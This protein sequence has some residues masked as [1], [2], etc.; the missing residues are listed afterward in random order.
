MRK[1]SMESD[2]KYIYN[3]LAAMYMQFQTTHNM[4]NYNNQ[5]T[6]LRKKYHKKPILDNF[7]TNLIISWA[8]V[9]NQLAEDYRNGES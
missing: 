6:E 8:P 2:I 9:I 7:C 3:T 1:G 5:A 4:I